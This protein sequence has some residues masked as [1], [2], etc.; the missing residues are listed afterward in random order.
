MLSNDTLS[1]SHNKVGYIPK[2]H[3]PGTYTLVMM[4]NIQLSNPVDLPISF[5]SLLQVLCGCILVVFLARY[6]PFWVYSK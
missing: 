5:S 4:Y 6:L 1:L 2:V 3:V